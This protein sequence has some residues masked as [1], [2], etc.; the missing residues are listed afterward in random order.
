MTNSDLANALL[1]ACQKRGIMLA[2]AESCTGGM[3]I[4]ALTDIAGSSAV[5]DRGFITYSNEAKMDML[6]VSAATLDAHGAVSRETAIEMA[7][8]ALTRSR[9]G[10]TLAVT[11]I[12]GPGGGSAEKPV[13]LVWFG[14]ALDGRPIGAEH[15]LFADKGRDFIRR[16][17]VRQA[18]ELGLQALG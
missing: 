11:G 10:L 16:E 5:V 12:A 6:G 4:A 1:Q 13:G 15:Q 9:A 17:T 7:T 18:L 8:G 3:I 2:T 14:V